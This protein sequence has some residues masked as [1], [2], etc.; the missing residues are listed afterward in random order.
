MFH[1]LVRKKKGDLHFCGDY[2]KLN[3]IT[4][5]D[6]FPLPRFDD[7]LDTLAGAKWFLNPD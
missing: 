1:V 4:R 7:T 6:C 2:R 3:D 5:K